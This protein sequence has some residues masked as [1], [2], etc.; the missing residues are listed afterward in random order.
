MTVYDGK[1]PFR[2]TSMY[3]NILKPYIKHLLLLEE[4]LFS[5]TD[6]IANVN[7]KSILLRARNW[8]DTKCRTHS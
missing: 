6:Q 7:R 1:V 2:P 3:A 8:K 4:I 5:E